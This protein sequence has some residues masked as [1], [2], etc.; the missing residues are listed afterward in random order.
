MSDTPSRTGKKPLHPMPFVRIE[1]AVL[2]VLDNRLLVLLGKRKQD[3]QAGRWALPGGVLRI[4]TDADLDAACQRLALERLGLGL[5][6][7]TQLVAVGGHGRDPRSSWAL[8]VV[9]RSMVS[10]G[11]L[12]AEP[13]KRLAEL[14]WV[15]AEQAEADGKLAF[16]H[17][18]I[19]S[20]AVQTLR[21][22]V[23]AFRFRLGLVPEIFTLGE[24]QSAAEAVLGHLLDKS[25]FRRKIEA[26]GIVEV[27]TGQ[28]RTGAFRPAQLF[29]FRR[30]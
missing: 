30:S 5:P 9:Y 18:R 8:S 23:E 7:A 4:D 19:I 12:S 27:Q 29:R 15:P 2:S 16:D 10:Q 3:P 14:K 25:S 21:E 11:Q 24:L 20:L 28:W 22:E 1:L 13:G 6:G 26:L 17:A